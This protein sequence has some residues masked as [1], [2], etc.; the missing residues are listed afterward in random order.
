MDKRL[1]SAFLVSIVVALLY[2]H[3]VMRPLHENQQQPSAGME[4]IASN[5]GHIALPDTA[6]R[7]DE[8]APAQ[9]NIPAV[10]PISSDTAL[11]WQ[12]FDQE[13]E[14]V[15]ENDKV[16]AVFTNIGACL[17]SLTVK[18]N[19]R[20]DIMLVSPMHYSVQPFYIDAAGLHSQSGVPVYQVNMPAEDTLTFTRSTGSFIEEKIITLNADSYQFDVSYK[21]TALDGTVFLS[22][23][24]G[25]S[26]G[27][28]QKVSKADKQE[29]LSSS[30]YLDIKKGELE[31][32]NLRGEKS[33]AR[34]TGDIVWASVKNKYFVLICKPSRKGA[35][36]DIRPLGSITDSN[37]T[38]L[39]SAQQ[40]VAQGQTAEFQFFAYC[41]PQ[42]LKYLTPYKSDFEKTMYFTGWFGPINLF[43]IK[44]LNILN[45][46][47]R[48]YGL[49]IILLTIII[50][51]IFYPLT[52]KSFQSMKKMQELQP[53]MAV[54]KEKYKDD[55]QRLQ[56]ETMA[57]Y[58]REKVNP[59]GGCLPML[60]QLPIFFGLYRTLYNAYELIDA[61][62]LWITSLAEPDKM[63]MIPWG[64]SS[65]PL[66]VLPLVMGVTMFYQQKMS[67]ADPQQQK[68]MMFMPVIFTFILY[69]LPSG[70][71]LYWT[72][73]NVLSILQQHYVKT[74]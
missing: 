60:I 51:I 21:I 6:V 28:I 36:L 7:Q 18:H 27:T 19:D 56:K 50:K 57:L 30:M 34:H 12:N 35:V 62:F 53:K 58:K 23:G 69:N 26:L 20:D 54:L 74:K 22:D 37:A 14:T 71:V 3:F 32:F 67:T 48:N 24:I 4:T 73:S 68:M 29:A 38:Y 15:L 65:F 8:P 13:Q 16:K 9:K 31:T 55:Q 52:H 5:D 40:P 72:L 49:A 39:R 42:L 1:F 33:V 47:C 45:S 63:F 2:Q 10:S 43:L 41:G 64:G 59:L 25:F 17:K 61:R 44:S 11:I 70:L 46:F 66:N